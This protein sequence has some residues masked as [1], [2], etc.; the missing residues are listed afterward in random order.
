MCY[1]TM[2][3]LEEKDLESPEVD[4][5]QPDTEEDQDADDVEAIKAENERLRKQNEKLKHKKAKAIDKSAKQTIYKEELEEFYK[6][7]K[8]Q[9]W[10]EQTHPNMDYEAIKAVANA[11][12]TDMQ[13][14]IKIL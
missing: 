6:E 11:K 9:E 1:D 14:A 13:E 8:Q 4:M 12:G 2:T 10:F 5:E 7:K 3:N